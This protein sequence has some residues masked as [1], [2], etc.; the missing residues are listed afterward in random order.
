[1][2]NLGNAAED[3]ERNLLVRTAID[4][5][6]VEFQ[7]KFKG[8]AQDEDLLDHYEAIEKISR[9]FALVHKEYIGNAY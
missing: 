9:R 7:K 8:M 1:M 2:D 3:L 4:V 6:Q 5:N